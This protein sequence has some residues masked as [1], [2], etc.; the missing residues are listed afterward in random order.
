MKLFALITALL[1]T[2]TTASLHSQGLLVPPGAPAPTMKTLEQIEPRTPISSIPFTITQ[3]GSY[4]VT[5]NLTM[6]GTSDGITIQSNN[7]TLDLGGFTLDGAGTGRHGV[8]SS[9]SF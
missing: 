3:P 2:A 5:R 4:Y 8:T 1:L 7:V 6:V 9:N